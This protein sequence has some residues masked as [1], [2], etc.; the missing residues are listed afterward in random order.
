MKI[1][2]RPA[3]EWTCE[4]CGRNQFVSCMVAEMTDSERLEQSKLMGLCDEFAESVPEYMSGD[5]VTYPDEVTCQF[6]Q[7]TFETL[8]HNG[9]IE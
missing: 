9:E 8:P 3:Y 7:S 2:M 1:E 5:F 4:N 6:C